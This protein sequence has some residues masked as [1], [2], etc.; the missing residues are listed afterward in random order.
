MN[1]PIITMDSTESRKLSP[2]TLL[3]TILTVFAASACVVVLSHYMH[4]IVGIWMAN[5]VLLAVFMKHR[6]RDWA[7][8]AGVGFIAICAANLI[9]FPFALWLAKGDAR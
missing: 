2:A 8:I 5:A 9:G 4:G 1:A 6:R 7:W 3:T